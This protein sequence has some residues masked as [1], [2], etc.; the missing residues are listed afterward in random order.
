MRGHGWGVGFKV[1][2]VVEA[3]SE[4]GELIET[5]RFEGSLEVV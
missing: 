1:D 2:S 3:R 4:R 5:F